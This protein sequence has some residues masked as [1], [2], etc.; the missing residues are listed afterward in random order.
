MLVSELV[1]IGVSFDGEAL[2]AEPGTWARFVE[3]AP[4]L[5]TPCIAVVAALALV[6]PS[7]LWQELNRAQAK[8]GENPKWRISLLG[9]ILAYAAFVAVTAV[10]LGADRP[11]RWGTALAILWATLGA[12]TMALAA[13]TVLPLRA[14]RAWAWKCR[15][16][17]ALAVPL[18]LLAW[19]VSLGL[20]AIGWNSLGKL[21]LKF[22]HLVLSVLYSSVVYEPENAVVGTPSFHVT[23]E[24]PCAGYQ[25]IGLITVFLA[26]YL[27][28]SRKQ[29]R[30]PRATL[31]IPLG[32]TLIWAANVLRIVLLILIGEAGWPQVALGGFHSQAGWLAFNGIALGM[33]ALAGRVTWLGYRP[34]TRPSTV[35]SDAT[36]AYLMPFLGIVA[37]AMLTGAMSAGFDWLYGMR[38]LVAAGLIA[39]FWPTYRDI[40]WVWSWQPLAFGSVAFL[41]WWGLVPAQAVTSPPDQLASLSKGWA[42]VWLAL[43][44]VGYVVTAPI[45]EELAFRGFLLR[46]FVSADFDQVPLARFHWLGFLGSSVLFG[47]MHGQDCVPATAAGMLFA[48]AA[49]R[50]GNL[51]DAIL[52]HATTNALV[53]ISVFTTGAWYLWG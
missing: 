45:A 6:S 33:V 44:T 15:H 12:I 32:I 10:L 43:R 2:E 49:Y 4:H 24:P 30:F 35:T 46:R 42:T 31:L 23:V 29:L 37:T 5:A 38:V 51:L 17:F 50:S 48:W 41:V 47:L 26:G 52:A 40:R 20:G 16:T 28:L 14:W 25:G 27:W 22:V 7:R 11:L 53:V 13:T 34:A 36:T 39:Y 21:T 9:H 19:T 18:G 1:A 8:F 3:Q